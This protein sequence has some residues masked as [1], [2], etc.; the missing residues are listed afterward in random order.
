MESLKWQILKN[1]ILFI[2]Y[3]FIK[4]FK[5]IIAQNVCIYKH[6]SLEQSCLAQRNCFQNLNLENKGIS[7]L[8][9]TPPGDHVLFRYSYFLITTIFL[10][11]NSSFIP[12]PRI[13]RVFYK[14]TCFPCIFQYIYWNITSEQQ[15]R[16]QIFNI[17]IIWIYLFWID[18]WSTYSQVHIPLF[19]QYIPESRSVVPT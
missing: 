7:D 6:T 14:K 15:V 13:N 18:I 4:Q 11:E 1:L 10:M 9:G 5:Q 16:L 12:L 2:I 3:L 8:C 19:L 17:V